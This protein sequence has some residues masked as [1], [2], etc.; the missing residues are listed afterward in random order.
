MAQIDFNPFD[1]AFRDDPYPRYEELLAASPGQILVDGVPSLFVARAAHISEVIRDVDR[2]SSTK[3]KL[4]GMERVDFFNGLPVISYVDPPEHTKLRRMIAPAFMPRMLQAFTEK[5]KTRLVELIDTIA[6]QPSIDFVTDVAD[7]TSQ[8]LILDLLLGVPREDW[9]IF[10][11]ITHAQ[12]LLARTP[13]G[14]EKPAEFTQA[15]TAGETYCARLMSD[16]GGRGEGDLI[17]T[18]IENENLEPDELL[19]MLLLLFT[20]G[21]N[22][23]SSHLSAG[24]LLLLRHPEQRRLLAENDAL[25]RNACEEVLRYDAPNLSTW[26]FARMDTEIFGYAIVKDTPIYILNGAANFDE[27]RYERPALFDITRNPKPHSSFGEGIHFCIGAPIA[28]MASQ[29]LFSEMS[30]RFPDIAL[31]ASDFRPAYEGTPTVRRMTTLPL[32]LK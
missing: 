21:L 29:T 11:A 18:L 6:D 12:G 2:F 13:P 9:P 30:R 24:M 22:T 27:E 1:P 15:W 14:G 3:P 17:R 26:R 31:A 10:L 8:E 19:A 16:H 4:P 32:R 7:R 5:A 23:V 28:R 20:A 25:A